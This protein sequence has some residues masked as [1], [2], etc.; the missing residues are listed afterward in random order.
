[1]PEI[2]GFTSKIERQSTALKILHPYGVR[3]QNVTT[4]SLS[5]YLVH[6]AES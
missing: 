6:T 1:M 3:F 4:G 5:A 2:A